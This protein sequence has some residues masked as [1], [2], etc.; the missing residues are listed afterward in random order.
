MW[1][2]ILSVS[3]DANKAALWKEVIEMERRFG[4]ID[5]TRRL[6]YI[7]VNSV[8]DKPHEIF[9]AFIQ[10]E[11]EE[12]TLEELDKALEKVNSQARRVQNQTQQ[13]QKL[14]RGHQKTNEKEYQSTKNKKNFNKNEN[15]SEVIDEDGFKKPFPPPPR[16]TD[17]DTKKLNDKHDESMD[18]DGTENNDN[19]S[20]SS[21]FQ[22]STGVEFN[23]LF[24]RNVDFACTESQLKVL[25]NN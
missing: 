23:K 8:T 20:T 2:E 11:R 16:F 19:T 18:H 3:G 25:F 6:F 9:S 22:Y 21:S 7:A 15:I 17:N 14:K 5:N 24:I 13:K 4:N 12:G 1:K 10:F